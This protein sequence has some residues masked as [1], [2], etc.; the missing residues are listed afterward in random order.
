M[1]G[2]SAAEGEMAVSRDKLLAMESDLGEMR[3]E[4]DASRADMVA[5][6]TTC[7]TLQKAKSELRIDGDGGKR[8]D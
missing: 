2:L 4:L 7:D 8:K 3:L 1:D 6:R 5:T